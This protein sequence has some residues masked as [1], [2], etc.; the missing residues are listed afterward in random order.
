MEGGLGREGYEL[1]AVRLSGRIPKPAEPTRPEAP[2]IQA[3]TQMEV[4]KVRLRAPMRTYAE[5]RGPTGSLGRPSSVHR[6]LGISS[7]DPIAAQA[8]FEL[9]LELSQD[10]E[11]ELAWVGPLV[12]LTQDIDGDLGGS[13]TG[14]SRKTRPW[15]QPVFLLACRTLY[16]SGNKE[17]SAA[18]N[19]WM[20]E[21]L[22]RMQA[23]D[24]TETFWE[25]LDQVLE[26][27]SEYFV[28]DILWKRRRSR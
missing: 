3:E 21:L 23:D 2:A 4:M 12:H 27:K 16:A 17:L 5:E 9:V 11:D 28:S 13:Y 8:A 6:S 10:R 1:G 14:L 20:D 7:L 24:S 25:Q 22:T 26:G 15:I 18:E 19:K